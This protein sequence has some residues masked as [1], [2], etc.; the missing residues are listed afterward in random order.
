MKGQKVE[1]EWEYLRHPTLLPDGFGLDSDR[2]KL[3][4]SEENQFR[5]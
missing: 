5:P 2:D 4:D 3:L 1:I